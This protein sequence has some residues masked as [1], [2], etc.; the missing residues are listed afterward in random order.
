MLAGLSAKRGDEGV[1]ASCYGGRVIIQTFSDHY[2]SMAKLHPLHV[3]ESLFGFAVKVLNHK[4]HNTCTAL[5][6]L[7]PPTRAGVV[8]CR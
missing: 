2:P 5:R 8:Q 6:S 3:E 4:G 1:L 7:A